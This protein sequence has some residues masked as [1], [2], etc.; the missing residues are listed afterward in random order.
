MAG[1]NADDV[2]I[3]AESNTPVKIGLSASQTGYGTLRYTLSYPNNPPVTGSRLVLEKIGGSTRTIASPAASGTFFLESG[4]YQMSFYLFY[5]RIAVRGDLVHIYDD[6]ETPAAFTFV[7]GDFAVPPTNLYTLQTAL[8]NALAAREGVR[9]SEDGTGVGLSEYWINQTTAELTA[10][11][12]KIAEAE[13]ILAAYG[14]G[15]NENGITSAAAALNAAITAFNAAKTAGAYDPASDTDLGL[16]INGPTRENAAGTTVDSILNYLKTSGVADNS[17]TAVIGGDEDLGPWLL[18]GS[19]S[20]TNRVFAGKTGVTLTLKGKGAE[21]IISLN[22]P[23]SLFTIASGVRLVLDEHIT[24]R[25]RADNNAPLVRVGSS[26]TLEME[27]G[28]KISGNTYSFSSSST[29]GGGGMYVDGG[30]FTMNGGDISGKTASNSGYGSGAGG[31]VY[32]NSGFFTMNNGEISGNTV[33]NDG[34]GVYVNSGFFT[35]NNG[36]IS[37]NTVS[38]D[39]GGVYVN[40]GTFTMSSGE[41]SGN[42]SSSGGGGVVV[43]VGGTFTMSGGVISDNTA[44]YGGGV[45][46][47]SGAPFTMSG[48]EI[49]GNTATGSGGGGVNIDG[50]FAMSGGEISGNTAVYGGGVNIYG[51]TSFNGTFAMSGGEISGNTAS[52]GGGVYVYPLGGPFTMSGGAAIN[53]NNP[54]YLADASCFIT[55]GGALTGIEPVALVQPAPA[56]AFIGKQV[57]RLAADYNGTLPVDRFQFSSGW[58]ADNDGIL[59]VEALSLAA[60]GE[61]AEAYLSRG[62]VHFYRFTPA[63]GKNYKVTHTRPSPSSSNAIFTAAAWAD[64]SGTLIT[65]TNTSGAS[66]TSTAFYVNK[67]GDIVIMVYGS[68]GSAMGVYTVTYNEQ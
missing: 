2:T 23:G 36:E 9:I 21:R 12:T 16:F 43:A 10:L 65:N 32:V 8:E 46:V 35:M 1:G 6:L 29:G 30:T 34:G 11:D 62:S 27:T 42:T 57:I 28:S 13:E 56:I 40:T 17:Y 3:T 47:G 4:Y 64:G 22:A 24:L 50:A 7:A 5:G 68:S 53:L 61:T 15:R 18:G 45:H 63:L 25:G 66:S 19:G 41:I 33:S 14:A 54:V 60:P 20:E 39:G 55:I 37:G 52:G 48:G 67:L 58:T 44:A 38:H 59:D 51:T 31:G 49:S 26:G